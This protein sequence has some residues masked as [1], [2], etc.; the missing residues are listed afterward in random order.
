MKQRWL[1]LLVSLIVIGSSGVLA[2]TPS[3]TDTPPEFRVTEVVPADGAV[4]V[5]TDAAITVIFNR[6]VVPLTVLDQRDTLPNPLT[7]L[8]DVP[9]TGEW[10]NTSIYVFRPDQAFGGGLQYLAI[11]ENL[12][13][14]DGTP[15]TP[16]SWTFR[17]VDPRV[18]R[19][20]PEPM[21]SDVRLE[22]PISVTFNMPM[23]PASVESAFTLQA[24]GAQTPVAGNFTW[25]DNNTAF[26]FQPASNLMLD[27]FY[28]ATLDGTTAKTQGGAS[29][30]ADAPNWSFLTVPAPAII[31]TSPVDGGSGIGLFEGVVLNFAS[32]MNKDTIPER[33]NVQP[34]PQ[35][36]VY[37][38]Y[39]TYNES[40]RLNFEADPSTT[41][42]VTIAPGMED[43]YG[44]TITQGLTFSYT[45]R[46]REP[47][48]SLQTPGQVGLYDALRDSTAL[49]VA[50]RNVSNISLNLY[51][52]PTTDLIAQLTDDSYATTEDYQPN[53]QTLIRDWTIDGST[54][55]QNQ[56]RYDLLNVGSSGQDCA[57]ALPTRLNVGDIGIVTT[58]PDPLRARSEPPNGEIV[59]LMY[60]DYRFTVVDGPRCIEGIPWFQVTLRDDTLA[61][62]AESIDGEYLVDVRAAAENGSVPVTNADGGPLA[63][64]IYYIRADAPE[65]FDSYN[66][67]HFMVVATAN[68]T[69]KTYPSG[70]TAWVTNIH[71]GQPIPGVSV[72]FVHSFQAPLGTAVTDQN[73]VASI[74]M[75][76]GRLTNNSRVVASVQT[77]E[78]FGISHDRWIE[79]INFWQFDVN[80]NQ[81]LQRFGSYLYTDRPIYRPDQ[82]VYF[83][84]ILR[85]K[86]DV[87][88]RPPTLTDVTVNIMGPDNEPI[89]TE[90]LALDS[91]GAFSD[92]FVLADDVIVGNYRI[93]I[94]DPDNPDRSLR[95][96]GFSVAEYR[97]PEYEVNVAPQQDEAVQG[98]VLRANVGA[99]YFFGGG[100]SDAAVQYTVE[101][102]PYS[103]RYAGDGRYSFR[104]YDPYSSR[105][106]Y[107]FG[108]QVA[109]DETETDRSGNAII[110]LPTDL[111][112]ESISQQLTVEATV[113]DETGVSVSGRGTAIV[114]QAEHYVG[115]GLDRYVN[116]TDETVT[117]NLITVDWDSLPVPGQAVDVQ[118]ERWQWV[119]V[120]EVGTNG[121]TAFNDELQ[122]Q[123][124]TSDTVVT[125]RDGLATFEF[126]PT[127]GG[128]YKILATSRDEQG[129]TVQAAQVI[130]VSGREYVQWRVGNDKSAEV[131]A[132]A[133]EYS[134]GDTARLL[135]TSPFQ[136]TTE[137]LI[138]VEREDVLMTEHV[139]LTGNSLVYDL[140]IDASYAPNVFFSVMLVKGVDDNN[141]VADFRYGVVQLNVDTSRKALNI[142]ITPDTD[143]AQPGE[144]VTYTV[145]TTDYA[146]APVPAQVGVGLTDLAALS[147]APPN[148]GPILQAFY[149]LQ[150]LAVGT[151]TPLTINT[152]QLTE[153]VRDVVKGGGGGGGGL[154]GIFEI[155]SE[156]VDTPY[157]NASLETNADGE[158]D[159]AVTLPDNLTTWRLDARAISREI[160]S[161]FLVG[162]DTFDLVSTKPLLVR[163]V[164]PRFF[165][166][167]DEVVL[168]S[169]VNNNT[170]E[171]QNVTAFIEITGATRSGDNEQTLSIP[172]GE[173]ARFE[174]RV[175][176]ENVE[177]VDV[178]FF[179][180]SDNGT[181]TD[182]SKSPVG[183]GDDRLLP[184]YRYDVPETVGTAGVIREAQALTEAIQLP[185]A[186]D[187]SG[188][189]LTV[190]LDPSLAAVT[191]DGLDYLR[192]F[193]HQCTEQT[194]SRFLPNI[195]TY[196][197]LTRLGLDDPA[198][199]S[200]LD[201]QVSMG[202]QILNT[203]Q[204]V[205]G[206]WGWFQRDNSHSL[207][208]AYV[209][210]GLVEAQ[211]AGYP[212]GARSISAARS[213]LRNNMPLQRVENIGGE[214]W[215]FNRE[216]F[217]LY[218]LA[219][220]GMPDASRMANLFEARTR[221][222]PEAKAYLA[223]GFHLTTPDDPRVDTLISDVISVASTSATGTFWS[224]NDPLNWTTQ[225]RATSVIL[226]ALVM[227]RPDSDLIPNVVR[228][229]VVSRD[230]DAWETT[231]ETAWAVMALTDWMVASGEL[232]ANYDY[233]VLLNGEQQLTGTASDT[234]NTLTVDVM[235]MLLGEV[236][237]LTFERGPGDGNLYYTA[238]LN[239]TLPVAEVQPAN[240]GITVARSYVAP[241]DNRQPLQ[242]AQVG[243]IVEVRLTVVAPQDL[244]Y[245]MVE[246]PIPAGMEPINPDL[247]T[248]AQVG[249]RPQLE[250]LDNGWGWWWFSDV[251]FRDEKVVL[252]STY[253]PAGTYEY[254]YKVRATVPGTYNV[255]PATAQEFYFPDVYGR[256]AGTTF[257]ILPAQ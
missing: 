54:I 200:A 113:R 198:L 239:A 191:L 195:I 189:N 181:Y 72:D 47:E 65:M 28:N 20:Q 143:R 141:P 228:Y 21:A 84:G 130:W 153:Y 75:N 17:T 157:W 166:V 2:Q 27:T 107:P 168:S 225:T 57:G 63:P 203:R 176:V 137:A 244:H 5:A 68:V 37:S 88:Y 79:G 165:V 116:R 99:S 229:L 106:L 242:Q 154:S 45:T 164:T 255:I 243:D 81:N 52:V 40:F 128:V 186:D 62:I 232:D 257:T 193:P 120:Q 117:A 241:G 1:W 25:Q 121:E 102:M 127:Q 218:T 174:W 156:F 140:P 51:D 16:F 70:A 58:E 213:Y 217:V 109:S 169:V 123:P 254:V 41:Y 95:Q 6:P 238:F 230:A 50:Y 236:N 226:E 7:L 30:G 199:K 136:G 82:P 105:Y 134:I 214:D 34:E 86:I 46:Q 139:T 138:T 187:I 103:F 71:T 177:H 170:G 221:L 223:L 155:R 212:V 222:N 55:P 13:S 29:L 159:F 61:W 201:E 197:A 251:E 76:N 234:E 167:G 160:E 194:V 26:S 66:P 178:T 163:P 185:A 150:S 122:Q 94:Q 146:G 253:L 96:I 152:D 256:G 206:G 69:L 179:A 98:G 192:N 124:I 196:Q 67:G 224:S 11:V 204:N 42:T 49:Y 173:R 43:V 219:R 35:Y 148:S 162:Q 131:I 175:A 171:P 89:Y 188:G 56:R 108:R 10:L 92:T 237:Q 118:I 142:E 4:D 60:R 23:D 18:T 38:F 77:P 145:R 235:S 231:Q 78:H 133:D 184:V 91:Y 147:L 59:E 248:S 240:N 53:P 9:G 15:I 112:G 126:T 114:H 144:T 172:A 210:L 209:L 220:S 87:T 207:V 104:D 14:F 183:L 119:T 132:D 31:S 216:A 64:G 233:Q 33:I 12:T 125:D 93:L 180:S 247:L 151:S 3:E 211:E 80:F 32:P 250:S 101:T 215:Q 202:L 73:G 205:D 19:V 227:T 110:D 115:V 22:T 245:V 97:L 74:R 249:T 129:N 44:N 100:V 24:D 190:N 161:P 246:D 158:A 8:P 39:S 90:T 36:G 135:V 208:T 252:Y 83:R 111:S 149:G 182:A 48:V 85:D